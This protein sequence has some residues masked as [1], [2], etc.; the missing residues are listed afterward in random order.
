M[1]WREFK[2]GKE[3]KRDVQ[4][5][6]VEIEDR[7]FAL[8][9]QLVSQ[10]YSH[11]AYTSFYI[12]DPK[13]RHIH[14]A[15]VIDRIVHHAI[16]RVLEPVFDTGFIYDSYSCREG[17]G[18]HKAIDRFRDF[19]W[20]VSKNNTKTVWILKCDIK[21][22]FDSIDHAVLLDLIWCEFHDDSLQ[23]LVEEVIGSFAV[24]SGRGLPL[25]NLT[26]QL[27]SNV[28]L[29]RLDQYV[30][31]VLRV[32]YYLRYADDFLMISDQRAHLAELVT[33][34]RDFLDKRLR[35]QLHPGKISLSKWHNGVDFLG[36]VSFP[37][38]RIL[39]TKTKRR[40]LR[41]AAQQQMSAIQSIS[42]VLSH[43]RGYG[44]TK[45]RD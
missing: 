24:S 12:K 37:H 10:K 39:R 21:K 16:V 8:H 34:L 9:A 42:G 31:R 25:G 3:N 32:S 33:T 11:G 23:W 20:S 7:I 4:E 1:A 2:K 6:S 36:Y 43:C 38:H 44:V 14:K 15:S 27:F 45:H 22:F 18:L 29:N 41:M 30:K 19:A 35:L 13:L 26:S 17:K 5:V 28:Y 40:F